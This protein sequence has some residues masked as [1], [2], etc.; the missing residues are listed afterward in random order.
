MIYRSDDCFGSSIAYIIMSLL[1]VF[2]WP[3]I[4][5]ATGDDMEI[6]I[7]TVCPV[8]GKQLLMYLVI[9]KSVPG[10]GELRMSSGRIQRWIKTPGRG[11]GKYLR[12]AGSFLN[13]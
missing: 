8:S 13:P 12:S 3:G 6:I 9:G 2:L 10:G 11:N 1:L 7:N 5:T 4:Y